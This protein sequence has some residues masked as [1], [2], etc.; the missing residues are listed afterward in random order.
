[1]RIIFPYLPV[2]LF[3]FSSLGDHGGPAAG[4]RLLKVAGTAEAMTK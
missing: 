2:K 4:N 3:V 1:M